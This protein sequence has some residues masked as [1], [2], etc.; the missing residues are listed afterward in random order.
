MQYT[1]GKNYHNLINHKVK[2]FKGMSINLYIRAAKTFNYFRYVSKTVPKNRWPF[3]PTWIKWR[4]HFALLQLTCWSWKFL[5]LEACKNGYTWALM[6]W[7]RKEYA[8]P[9]YFQ[10]TPSLG[11][12]YQVRLTWIQEVRVSIFTDT[13]KYFSLWILHIEKS[14]AR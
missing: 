10:V 14:C 9:G 3:R 13:Q 2:Q 11:D 5:E 4:N 12:V 1:P 6:S 8:H 7:F